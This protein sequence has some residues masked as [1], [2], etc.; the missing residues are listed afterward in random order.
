[1]NLASECGTWTRSVLLDV[2]G[3]VGRVDLPA[4]ATA[5]A[6]WLEVAVDAPVVL[7]GHST[8][9]QVALRAAV[10]VPA[11]VRVLVLMSP[12]F[13]PRLRRVPAL[14]RA[15]FRNAAHEPLDVWRAV[16]PGCARVGAV[17][18]CRLLRSAQHDRPE[19]IVTDV[20]CPVLVVRGEHDAFCP[21][22]WASRLGAAAR[23]GRCVNVLG[24][25]GFP[26]Q[27]D[28][29]T[30]ALIADFAGRSG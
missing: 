26:H 6:Q 16:L 27:Y 28:K 5:V 30:S 12:T 25:H 15:N 23:R 1:M 10:Q 21:E 22:P 3:S 11:A 14:V 8:G 24:A 29:N 7:A 20:R 9:A 19:E 18:L 2:L 4:F 13:P 17:T